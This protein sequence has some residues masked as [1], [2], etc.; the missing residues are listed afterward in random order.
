MLVMLGLEVHLV[1]CVVVQMV[2]L[3]ILVCLSLMVL[4]GTSSM[5]GVEVVVFLEGGVEILGA[6]EVGTEIAVA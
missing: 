1:P 5:I 2:L 6:G 3:L 4:L